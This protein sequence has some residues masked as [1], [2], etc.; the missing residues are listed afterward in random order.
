MHPLLV[1]GWCTCKTSLDYILIF[2][3]YTLL[4]IVKGRKFNIAQIDVMSND[5]I[6]ISSFLIIVCQL[7]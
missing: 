5:A 7:T 2:V 1:P 6:L 4:K 3:F